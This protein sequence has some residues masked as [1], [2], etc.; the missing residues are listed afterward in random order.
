MVQDLGKYLEEELSEDSQFMEVAATSEGVPDTVSL[1][2]LPEELKL[3]LEGVECKCLSRLD[4]LDQGLHI[5]K[6]EVEKDLKHIKGMNKD[7]QE[8]QKCSNDAAAL[9]RTINE[10]ENGAAN[11]SFSEGSIKEEGREEAIAV[12]YCPLP[13]KPLKNS[14]QI[15]KCDIQHSNSGS[16]KKYGSQDNSTFQETN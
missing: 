13:I 5:L 1:L 10:E 14:G 15:L 2:A 16:S 3:E 9:M 7:W 12:L 4:E 8:L 11:E 6:C